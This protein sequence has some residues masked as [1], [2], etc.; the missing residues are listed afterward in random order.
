MKKT[1]LYSLIVLTAL[2]VPLGAYA[3]QPKSTD[4][5]I[6]PD[7]QA[8]HELEQATQYTN[9]TS[10]QPQAELLISAYDNITDLGKYYRVKKDSKYG[11]IDKN[12]NIILA[13]VFQR[14]TLSVIDGV[15]CFMAKA[16]G[17]LRIYYNTGKLIPGEDLYPIEQNSSILA[18]QQ[19]NPD[20][21]VVIEKKEVV[22]SKAE[23]EKIPAK[24]SF[25]YEI[26]EIPLIKAKDVQKEDPAIVSVR[27]RYLNIN[28]LENQDKKDLVTIQRTQYSVLKENGFVGLMDSNNNVIIPPLYDSIQVKTPCKHFKEPVFLVTLNGIAS[29]Y[30]KQGKVLLEQVEN[31]INVYKD[32]KLYTYNQISYDKGIVKENGRLIG[33]LTKTNTGYTYSSAKFTFFK[34]HTVNNLILT[35]L[36]K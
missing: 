29:I 7:S 16:D 19:I 31:Q 9:P 10:A 35:V 6:V 4:Y 13:P 17:K 3:I 18:E 34:P 25:V 2:S 33:Y 23:N 22:Y 28:T 26:K 15:D 30:D 8:N 12:G 21:Q 36:N 14:V 1:L 32:G 27:N 11:I 24:D 5:I 20:F